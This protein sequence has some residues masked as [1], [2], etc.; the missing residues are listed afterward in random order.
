MYEKLQIIQFAE[1]NGKGAAAHEFGT[2][3]SNVRLWQKS[4]ENLEMM[5]WLQHANPEKKATWP[6]LE[7]DLLVW[8]TE[9]GKN[10]LAILPS[11][12]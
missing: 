5:P 7:T 10:S 6:E 4:K 2:S 3:E 12:V 1:Q 8:I 11:M 9:M